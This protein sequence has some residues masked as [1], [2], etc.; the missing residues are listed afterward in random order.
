[1]SPYRTLPEQPP[2]APRDDAGAV[3]AVAL[4][5]LMLVLALLARAPA[6]PPSAS[7][8]IAQVFAE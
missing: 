6:E 7:T 4:T 3:A 2:I 5:F 1:M 8:T